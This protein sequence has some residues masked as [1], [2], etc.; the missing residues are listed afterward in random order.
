M[1]VRPCSNIKGLSDLDNGMRANKLI[2]LLLLCFMMIHTTNYARASGVCGPSLMSPNAYVCNF[3]CSMPY[4]FLTDTQTIML[5]YNYTATINTSNCVTA[6]TDGTI[7]TPLASMD[8]A[9]NAAGAYSVAAAGSGGIANISWPGHHGYNYTFNHHDS[10]TATQAIAV[11]TVY[12]SGS[13]TPF[14]PVTPFGGSGG[15]TYSISP[16]LPT[17]L[18]LNTSTGEISGTPGTIDANGT[19][20]SVTITDSDLSSASASFKLIIIDDLSA[21]ASMFIPIAYIGGTYN[22]KP[23]SATGG[24]GSYRYALSSGTLPGGLSLDTSTGYVSG[25]PTGIGGT[26]DFQIRVTDGLGATSV[27]IASITVSSYFTVDPSDL[28]SGTVGVAYSQTLTASD[29][30]SPY[31][32][33]VSSGSLPTGLSLSSSGVISGTPTDA[34][35]SSF[36]VEVTDDNSHH[37][38]KS[39]TISIDASPI[40][41]PSKA[42]GVLEQVSAHTSSVQRFSQGQ[43]SNVSGHLQ[44]LQDSFGDSGVTINSVSNLNFNVQQPYS[45]IQQGLL[46]H[47]DLMCSNYRGVGGGTVPEHCKEYYNNRDSKKIGN[48]ANISKLR[49]KGL[50]VSGDVSYG[51]MKINGTKNRFYTSGLSA[52]L[53]RKFSNKMVVGSSIGL[54][55]DEVKTDNSGSKADSISPSVSLYSIYRPADKIF[56]NGLLGYGYAS[57]KNKRVDA[58]SNSTAKGDRKANSI[59]ASLGTTIRFQKEGF[60]LEPF[61]R[62]DFSLSKLGSYSERGAGSSNLT[63]Q[64]MIS[65]NIALSGG[66]VFAYTMKY[67]SGTLSPFGKVFFTYNRFAAGSQGLYY[68]NTPN[69]LDSIAVGGS[70]PSGSVTGNLGLRY[71]YNTGQ[72][73]EIALGYTKGNSSYYAG[74]LSAILRIPF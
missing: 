31:T 32:F 51:A 24:Q 17:G 19:F 5:P 55:W 56:I 41:L 4:D 37:V 10:L 50:W 42:P 49:S 57:L 48:I 69:T 15:N 30:S 44:S 7:V 22:Q 43:V 59:F 13:I 6:S 12:V 64:S 34:G 27:A 58:T 46:E 26:P 39:Y 62:G 33:S 61:A 11:E 2:F 66:S 14:T 70:L 23:V 28:P 21:S 65:R 53:D 63:Y 68:S 45:M 18:S 3:D 9:I 47:D 38:F 16:S 8:V 20:Y 74:S 54:G 52:G 36:S 25:T 1:R 60:K 29:G 35:S 40:T 71:N 72:M 67:D 73:C